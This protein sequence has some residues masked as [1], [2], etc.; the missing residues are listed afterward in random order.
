MIS[1]QEN[2]EN[3]TFLYT[4]HLLMYFYRGITL[5]I[6]VTDSCLC[7]IWIYRFEYTCLLCIQTVIGSLMAIRDRILKPTVISSMLTLVGLRSVSTRLGVS[8]LGLVSQGLSFLLLAFFGLN[9]AQCYE[10]YLNDSISIGNFSMDSC[11]TI[12]IIVTE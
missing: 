12:G 8:G 1:T 3:F 5:L 9:Q 4:K 7:R 10:D 6:V 2:D 11:W